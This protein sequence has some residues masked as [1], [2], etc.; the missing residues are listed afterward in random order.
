M[1]I[2]RSKRASVKVPTE[3]QI[4]SA[5]F[6]WLGKQH[7]DVL[8]YA[9]PNAA[10]RSYGA[11]R[12]LQ[13]EGL[14]SGVPDVCI[15]KAVEPFHGMYLEFKREK[16]GRLSEHQH[17]W[18]QKLCEEGYACAVVSGLDAAI[19][20]AKCYLGGGWYDFIQ[21]QQRRMAERISSDTQH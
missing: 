20:A 15:C 21:D 3:H 2:R 16:G 4:Q 6:D 7:R 19:T 17:D 11:A 12:Y 8:A 13:A 14:K 1:T 18:L 10:R 9:V 5:F